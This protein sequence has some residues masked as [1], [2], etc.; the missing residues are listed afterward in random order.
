MQDNI[1]DAPIPGE[2]LTDTPGNA[3]W[4]HPPQFTDV[5]EAAEHI[6]DKLHD[7]NLLQQVITFLEDDIPVEA[8]ARMI[9]FSG[10]T[11]GKWTPDVAILLAEVVFKQ[12]MAIGMRAEIPKMKMFMGD[13]SNNQF[14]RSFAKFNIK[15]QRAKEASTEKAEEFA[16]EIKEEITSSGLMARETE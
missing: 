4:E 7:R 15:K 6:W 14:H 13:Q 12:I 9:L 8:I 3:S 1:F 10:F 5:N 16:E 11:E 2:S